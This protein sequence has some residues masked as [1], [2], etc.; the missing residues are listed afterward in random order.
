MT[1]RVHTAGTTHIGMRPSIDLES[2]VR[3]REVAVLHDVLYT[4]DRGQCLHVHNDT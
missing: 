2:I 1:R 3:E 4:G